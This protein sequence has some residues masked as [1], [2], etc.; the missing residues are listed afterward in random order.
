MRILVLASLLAALQEPPKPPPAPQT[1]AAPAAA[2]Q[3][4]PAKPPEFPRF[5]D[6]VRDLEVKKGY[7]TLYQ[8]DN[9]LLAEI[10][11][12]RLNK[13][14]L[15]ATSFARGG[16]SGWMWEEYLVQWIRVD[17]RLLLIEPEV[18]H[19]AR[20]DDPLASSVRRNYTESI[21]AFADIVTLTPSG[22]PV[23]DLFMLLTQ[24]SPQF[25]GPTF[26]RS[27]LRGG[28]D[29]MTAK[30]HQLKVFPSNL[31]IEV[32]LPPVGRGPI[33][34]VHYSL[35]ELKETGY[36]PRLADDRVGY[37]LTSV[38]DY[39]KSPKD[40]SRFVRY[41][42]RWHIQKADPRLKLSPPKEPIVFYIEK[43][44]PVQ[45]RRAVREGILEWNKAFERIGISEAIVVRQQ[46]DTNEFAALDPEDV[47]YNF[48][49]WITSDRAF[50]MGPSRVDPRTGQILDADIIFDD[51][52]I[53]A[54]LQDHRLLIGEAARARL[55]PR[56]REF[57]EARPEIDPLLAELP[58]DRESRESVLAALRER[59]A[60]G[61]LDGNGRKACS[62]GHGLLQ[63]MHLAQLAG[64]ALSGEDAL[65]KWPEEF[66][67]QVVKEIVM[68]EVGHTLGL[69]HNFKAS[70]WRSLD[71]LAGE[72]PPE[73]TS[74]SVMDYNPLWIPAD[75]KKPARYVPCTIGPYDYWAIEY[76]Y[77]PLAAPSPEQ[78]KPE[79]DKIARRGAEKGLAYG[80]DEDL[81]S[82]DPLI[83]LFDFGSDPLA[84][85]VER[86]RLV[87]QIQEKLLD[88]A[89]RPGDSYAKAR[90]AFMV[91]LLERL[92][93]A[94]RA[95]R[96]VG[97]HSIA[98]D[99]RGDPGERPPVAPLTAD[100]Q[101][102]ALAFLRDHVFSD[103]AY[104]FSPDLLNRLGANRWRDWGHEFDFD[105]EFPIHDYVLLLQRWAIVGV[106]NPETLQRVMDAELR[107]PRDRDA[108]TL[109]EVFA[110]LT[111]AVFTE[112]LQPP[113]GEAHYSERQPF[114]SSFRRN[115]QRE[116][117]AHLIHMSLEGESRGWGY[118]RQARTL[119]WH[120]LKQ[121]HDHID[122]A[123][124]ADPPPAFDR[125]SLSHL[126]EARQRIRRALDAAFSIGGGSGPR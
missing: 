33:T 29:P 14:F 64:L 34:T 78:E 57:L 96:H 100:K 31:E 22:A 73:D 65:D 74:G 36:R 102:E 98:R 40:D 50:A 70:S 77:K 83:E 114:L 55:S 95:A 7:Y 39:S 113:Q 12:E 45:Y 105:V 63:Q 4:P 76:G 43:T 87:Q 111:Q 24:R 94:G 125:Y 101:R 3:Q 81:W 23:I 84:Y 6:V 41:I 13:P 126:E 51:A 44:V 80:T 118:P 85:S 49:R 42:N 9:R 20:P 92:E 11:A 26:T 59:E 52:M 110:S 35:S 10:P 53:R 88:R 47:R 61:M 69:R 8:K 21:I 54:Y 79:L 106:L 115:L 116:Y 66:V 62:L 107:T 71:E 124:R 123:L 56:L 119:A 19:R 37:F 17:R 97:G 25:L 117:V 103:A 2:P 112:I 58:A 5:E 28:I 89:V 68:H 122:R 121:I 18:R 108:L 16:M 30:L 91:L 72:A 15:L 60:M 46:T 38:K 109:P 75:P 120:E 48:F 99:H 32:D 82:S 27:F 86:M 93:A 1:P 90:R 104:R 67:D